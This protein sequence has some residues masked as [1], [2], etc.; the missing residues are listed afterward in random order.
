MTDTPLPDWARSVLIKSR[1]TPAHAPGLWADTRIPKDDQALADERFH[2]IEAECYDDYEQVPRVAA[3]EP[4]IVHWMISHCSRGLVV[5]LGCGTGRIAYAAA[6]ISNHV[7][8]VDRSVA[9]LNKM[10]NKTAGL[11]VLG[12]RA[13]VRALPVASASVDS[14]L[15]SGVLHHLREPGLV[16]SEAARMLRPGGTIVIR[17]PNLAYSGQWL[18]PLEAFIEC[19][20]KAAHRK[21]RRPTSAKDLVERH[22]PYERPIH[23]G[24]LREQ[25]NLDFNSVSVGSAKILASLGLPAGLPCATTYYQAANRLDRAILLRLLPI[26]G[27]LVLAHGRR[28]K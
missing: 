1:V 16:L 13:D 24:W 7:I 11:A 12:L 18:A 4:W 20:Y 14:I 21:S 6:R 3:A 23:P 28:R 8:A 15:C 9:M 2:D 26:Q 10:L 25:L 5:D 22:G 27:S 19:L 17:E